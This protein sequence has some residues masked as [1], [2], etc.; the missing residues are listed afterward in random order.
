MASGGIL[1]PGNHL[2]SPN[3]RFMLVMQ[4]DG[5]LVDYRLPGKVPQWESDTSGNFGA[6][7]VMQI[8]GDLVVYPKGKAAPAPGQPTSALWSSGTGGHRGS[9]A[10]L[11][12]SGTLI[13]RPPHGATLLWRSQT[14]RSR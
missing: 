10:A 1:Q 4:T 14:N 7:V 3:G 9:T 2:V 6:Y 11:L 5:N 8:D 12:N 13:V